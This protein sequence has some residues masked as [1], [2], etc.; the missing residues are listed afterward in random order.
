MKLIKRIAFVARQYRSL[1]PEIWRSWRAGP[2]DAPT[3]EQV[4]AFMEEG[5]VDFGVK[6]GPVGTP[7]TC[8]K[9]PKEPP[10]HITEVSLNGN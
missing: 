1:I 9:G 3:P 10:I 5:D 2:Y 7:Q 6:I 4:K 8:H